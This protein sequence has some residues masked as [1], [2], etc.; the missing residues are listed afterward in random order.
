MKD[1]ETIPI[2]PISKG[3]GVYLEDFEG[4]RSIDAI[5]SWWVNLFGHCNPYINGKIK[6][7]L[8]TTRTCY[9]GGIYP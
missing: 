5:S 1:H 9:F 3:D 8:D 4:N 2:V 6:A 7:Q